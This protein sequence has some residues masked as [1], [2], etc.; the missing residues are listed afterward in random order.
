R[1][2]PKGH[3]TFIICTAPHQVGLPTSTSLCARGAH[4]AQQLSFVVEDSAREQSFPWRVD[5]MVFL[6]N[7]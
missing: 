7:V 6:A 2:M 5:V 4:K 3:K 1:A